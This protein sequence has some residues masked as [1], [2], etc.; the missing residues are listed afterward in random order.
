M[1][2]KIKLALQKCRN[3]LS[4]SDE[5]QGVVPKYHNILAPP[6]FFLP[7]KRIYTEIKA[8]ASLLL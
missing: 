7:M 6:F 5:K 2:V 4:V 3:L 8:S 1:T